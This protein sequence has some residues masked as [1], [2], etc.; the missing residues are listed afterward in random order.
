MSTN[1][2]QAPILKYYVGLSFIA[3][4]LVGILSIYPPLTVESCAWRKPLIGS[5]FG[6]ICLLGVAAVFFPNQCS[7]ALSLSTR[8]TGKR[9][10]VKGA[11][12]HGTSPNTKGHHPDCENFSPHVFELDSR[13]FCTACAGLLAGALAS[14][15][16]TALYFFDGL[17]V[18][19]NAP[20]LV[21]LGLLGVGAGLFQYKARR[22]AIR[23]SLNMSFVLGTFLVLM[24]IDEGA[25]NVFADMFL[26]LLTLFWLY[27]RI[28]ISQW[29]HKRICSTCNVGDCELGDSLRD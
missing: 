12:L 28:L 16:G 23:F 7:Q 22:A 10:A 4:F 21:W 25:Q 9:S 29:D 17:N 14:I 24:G 15:V 5:I 3:I 11:G 20:L 19:S 18:E 2:R 8:G 1:L 26:V 27:T 13:T 6:L